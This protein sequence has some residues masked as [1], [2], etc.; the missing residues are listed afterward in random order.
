MGILL[1]LLGC[2]ITLIVTAIYLHKIFKTVNKNYYLNLRKY[3]VDKDIN[4]SGETKW[5]NIK[6]MKLKVD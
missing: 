6:E 5:K 2:N 1:L 4:L 3:A